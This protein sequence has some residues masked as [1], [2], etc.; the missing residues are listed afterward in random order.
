MLSKK[1]IFK[2]KWFEEPAEFLE[3]DPWVV[4]DLQKSRAAQAIW[5][6]R[7][8]TFRDTKNNP[9]QLEDMQLWLDQWR[10]NYGMVV[11]GDRIAHHRKRRSFGMLRRFLQRKCQP[12]ATFIDYG[13]GTYYFT[14]ILSEFFPDAQ[15]ILVD[16]DAPSLEYAYRRCRLFANR[17]KKIVIHEERLA[18][19]LPPAD[20]ILC[21]SV[22]EHLWYP[23]RTILSMYKSI[24]D[25]GFIAMTLAGQTKAHAQKNDTQI[26]FDM[27]DSLIVFMYHHFTLIRG[28]DYRFRNGQFCGDGQ[29][30]IWQK[31]KCRSPY[32]LEASAANR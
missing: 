31:K 8:A 16:V 3:M 28:W 11:A 14:R 5:N 23:E 15:Y 20:F 24:K 1:P 13:C 29:L 19:D 9:Q 4:R 26:S 25:G 7:F 18:P 6:G 12:T 27:R 32:S 2:K 30:K 17:V 10:R 22:S 21:H